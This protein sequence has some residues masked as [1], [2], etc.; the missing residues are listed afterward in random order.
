MSAAARCETCAHRVDGEC[1]SGKLVEPG[2]SKRADDELVYSYDEGGRFFPGP[3]FGCVHHTP[4]EPKGV[5][6]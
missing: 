5:V 2:Q 3:K 4:V 1:L 6:P